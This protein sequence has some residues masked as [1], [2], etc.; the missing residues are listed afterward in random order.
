MDDRTQQIL[1]L[2]QSYL[3]EPESIP[4][5]RMF[6]MGGQYG[7][8]LL[9]PFK[10]KFMTGYYKRPARDRL[11][12]TRLGCFVDYGSLEVFSFFREERDITSSDIAMSTKEGYSLMHSVAVGLARR[13][14]EEVIPRQRPAAFSYSIFDKG[15]YRMAELLA[16]RCERQDLHTQEEVTPWDTDPVPVWR[17]TPLTSL[18]GGTLCF[19]SPDYQR[20]YWDFCF[21]EALQRWVAGLKKG[22]VDLVQYGA[23]EQ[24]LLRDYRTGIKGAFDIDGIKKSRTKIRKS[25]PTNAAFEEPIHRHNRDEEQ[26]PGNWAKDDT[27]WIPIRLV[28]LEYGP[29]PS[30]WRLLWAP[31]LEVF[32][33]EFWQLVEELEISLPGSWVE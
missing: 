20:Y 28:D 5:E 3:E 18:V 7:Y 27:R 11:E 31:E 13:L 12:A 19:L 6:D 8:T 15:W 2:F 14:P 26:R 33:Y 30:D 23:R 16:S 10:S 25:L 29:N 24:Q 32:A 1:Q 21:Q 17:G 22:G 4:I 9:E